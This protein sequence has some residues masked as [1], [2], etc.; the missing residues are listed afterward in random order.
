M[1]EDDR[2]EGYPADLVRDVTLLDG[3]KVQ[4]RPILPS[5][6]E[7]LRAAVAQAD[8]ET[9]RM[10]FLGGRPPQTDADFDHLVRVDYVDRLAVVAVA[11]DGT[12]VGLARYERL[13]DRPDTA[14]VAVAVD[15]A[16]RHVRCATELV[17]LLGEG[18][19]RNGVRRF[20]AE[21]FA[22]NLDVTDLLK[23][24]GLRYVVQPDESGVVTVDVLL[25]E[26]QS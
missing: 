8:P 25:P 20:E 6:E 4:L 24:A 13:R 1:A 15:P 14:E 26:P 2:P 5:D 3:R 16:W 18:A 11:P 19:L 21:F 17:T 23:E 10:R 7:Q 9:L 12:G 22:D